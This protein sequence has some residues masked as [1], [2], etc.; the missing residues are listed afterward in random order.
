VPRSSIPI[1]NLAAQLRTTDMA[2]SIR[3][4]TEKLGFTVAF[5]YQD[6]YAGIQAGNQLF[7]LKLVDEPD[8]SIQYVDDGGHLHLYFET[9]DIAALAGQ[10]RA[11]GVEFVKAVHE[12]AWSTREFVIRDDQAHTL[13]F[14]QPLDVAADCA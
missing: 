11:N 7:H 9:D 6:F 10:Y 12:T 5:N 4:Y 1:K 2:A 3:F 13:Y 8:P 14:V